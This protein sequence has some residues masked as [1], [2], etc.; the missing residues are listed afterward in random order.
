MVN[1]FDR[2]IILCDAREPISVTDK[3]DSDEIIQIVKS[4]IP[5]ACGLNVAIL[6]QHE[7]CRLVVDEYSL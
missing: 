1:C 6:R 7:M 5:D 2:F 4:K 3:V